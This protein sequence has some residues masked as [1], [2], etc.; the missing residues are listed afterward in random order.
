MVSCSKFLYT[1]SPL[2]SSN[3]L[4]ELITWTQGS[5]PEANTLTIDQKRDLDV[6]I[7][8]AESSNCK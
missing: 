6:E 2:M 4:L 3:C 8:G 7:Q 1:I 5:N